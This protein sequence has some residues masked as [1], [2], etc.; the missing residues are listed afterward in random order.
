MSDDSDYDVSEEFRDSENC[1]LGDF[2]LP[3]S[4]LCDFS[5]ADEEDPP[6]MPKK[7]CKK[8][9]FNFYSWKNISNDLGK[10][11]NC[12]TF[13]EV[14]CATLAK[15]SKTMYQFFCKVFSDKIFEYLVNETNKCAEN[16][17]AT[18][19]LKPHSTYKKWFPFFEGSK[20]MEVRQCQVWRI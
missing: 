1:A 7:Q 20:Q 8:S 19:T 17:L 5:V 3:P 10:I 2:P 4:D 9:N 16:F 11:H 15:D 12:K 18:A 13:T 14:N 6:S